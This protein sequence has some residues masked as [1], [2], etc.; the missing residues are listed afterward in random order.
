MENASG[1]AT[2][3]EHESSFGK[4]YVELGGVI[5]IIAYLVTITLLNFYVIVKIWP[6]DPLPGV[7][8][9]T[10]GNPPAPVQESTT[11][12]TAPIKWQVSFFWCNNDT[13]GTCWISLN[14]ALFLIVI[15]SGAL[16]SLLHS[17]RS[18]YWYA[19]NRRL[20]W[21][22]AVMYMLLPFSGAVLATIFYIIIRAGF[23]PSSGG[24]QTIPN[25]PYGFAALGA[26]VGLFSEEAVLKLKQVAETVFSKT[27]PGKDHATPPPK[28]ASISPNTGPAAG[29]TAVTVAGSDFSAGA[30]VNIG[31]IPSS[32]ITS[33][34]ATSISATTPAKIPG[35]ADI[36]VINPDGQKGLLTGGYT[37]V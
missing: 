37:Y 1:A 6:P 17:L 33:I 8:T 23:L 10:A 5:L 4:S 20:V 28:I 36:E 25:T 29:G 11:R 18:L 15:L 32:S 31:G 14:T 21:S 35:Q 13:K 30:K 12:Q 3:L 24:T 7:V 16:G 34:T 22:W 2:E 27:Q 26:L 19:G 9:T